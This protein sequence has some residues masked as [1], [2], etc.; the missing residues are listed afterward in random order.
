MEAVAQLSPKT[1]AIM[2][3]SSFS[4]DGARA[5]RDLSAVFRDVLATES[6]ANSAAAD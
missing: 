4:G 2:H 1:L 6:A 5:I 3:G